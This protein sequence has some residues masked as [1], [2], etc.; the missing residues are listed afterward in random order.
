MRPVT[1]T[2]EVEVKSASTKEIWPDVVLNGRSKR[3]TPT[4]MVIAK[5]TASN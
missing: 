4:R 2:A 1:Q 3:R 5:L